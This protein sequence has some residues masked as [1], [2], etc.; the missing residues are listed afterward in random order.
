MYVFIKKKTLVCLKNKST[1]YLQT[2]G[3]FDYKLKHAFI[4]ND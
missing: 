4:D 3:N 2:A 1:D